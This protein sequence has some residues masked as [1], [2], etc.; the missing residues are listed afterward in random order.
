MIS[1][2]FADYFTPTV[3]DRQKKGIA[4]SA[5]PSIFTNS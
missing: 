4:E 2:L 3:K 5:M 1:G